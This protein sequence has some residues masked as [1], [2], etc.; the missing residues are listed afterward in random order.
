MLGRGI[1]VAGFVETSPQSSGVLGL[2]IVDWA[3]LAQKAPNAQIAIGILNRGMPYDQLL[4]I[5]K[6]AGFT[7]LLMPW[8]TYDKFAKELG[9]R[10]W[11]RSHRCGLVTPGR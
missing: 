9:W 4:Q 10:F 11:P 2:P 6:Q 3:A 1:Q 7:D 8:D 5:A